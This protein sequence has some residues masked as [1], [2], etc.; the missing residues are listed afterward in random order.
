MMRGQRFIA[1]LL[2]VALVGVLLGRPMPA[3]AMDGY[4]L[5]GMDQ[6]YCDPDGKLA[7]TKGLSPA[8]TFCPGCIFASSLL[9]APV[10]LTVPFTA[11]SV[12]DWPI[13]CTRSG[14]TVAPE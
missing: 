12:V 13:A 9:P 1:I 6:G 14:A 4:R 2:S 8:C 7:S 10:S 3:S 5:Y 11:T